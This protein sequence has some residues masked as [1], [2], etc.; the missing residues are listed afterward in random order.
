MLSFPTTPRVTA[1]HGTDEGIGRNA[2]STIHQWERSH[3]TTAPLSEREVRDA[4]T[5]AGGL[6]AILAGA[7]R[8]ERAA[9]YRALGLTLRY[10]KQAPTGAE[11]VHVRL[12][13]CGGGGSVW[14]QDIPDTCRET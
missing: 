1:L 14:F 3:T 2:R 12:E 4:L 11:R 9:L 8:T 13:L 6:V 7:D 10:E 5:A